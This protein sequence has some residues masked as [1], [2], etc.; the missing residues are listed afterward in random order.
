MP[1]RCLQVFQTFRNEYDMRQI[2]FS[3]TGLGL[4]LMLSAGTL[5]EA[6]SRY[7]APPNTVLSADLAKPWLL[8]LRRLPAGIHTV[9]TT[10]IERR[11]LAPIQATSAIPTLAVRAASP[12]ERQQIALAPV[13]QP[14]EAETEFEPKFLPQVVEYSGSHE[15][16]T[17]VIDTSK[18]FLYLVQ[19]DG[20]A[21]RYR[22]GVG[23]QGFTWSGSHTI[24][25][26]AEWPDWRPPKEMIERERNEGRELPEVV[27]G[28]PNNPLGARALYIGST[29][30]RIHGT[31]QPWSIGK[32]VSSG[33]IRMRNEDVIDLYERVKTGA[34]VVVS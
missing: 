32:A 12:H 6:E 29:L 24:T 33:C 1:T 25:R 15:P 34:I 10:P 14:T 18:R 17:I 30:Y 7:S 27:E 5:A 2:P 23:R 13:A 11:S 20:K 16:G 31:N 22:A 28:G 21:R 8:Q 19:P 26:T 3:A 9:S 4:I